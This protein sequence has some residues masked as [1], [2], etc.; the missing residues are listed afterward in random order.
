MLLSENECRGM[1]RM[2]TEAATEDAKAKS[3]G[4]DS[5]CYESK[6]EEIRNAAT[7]ERS[8]VNQINLRRLYEA[9]VPD[10]REA[11]RMLE[12]DRYRR[13][14]VFMEA[15]SPVKTTH[16]SNVLSNIFLGDM[17]AEMESP[18]LIGGDLLTK[19]PAESQGPEM[20]HGIAMIGD[21]AQ[22][23]GEGEEYPMVGLSEKF[24]TQPRK[25]KDG[26]I[27][28]ITDEVIW[29]NKLASVVERAR[30]A[31]QGMALTQEKDRLSTVL[32]ITNSY[33]RNGGPV[34][35]TYAD[36]HTQGDFDNLVASNAMTDYTSINA[37]LQRLFA[38]VDLDTGEPVMVGTNFQVVYPHQLAV[39]AAFAF[40][41]TE[42]RQVNGS[43]TSIGGNPISFMKEFGGMSFEFKSNQY[44]SSVQGNATSWYVGNFRD[45]FEEREVFP[46]QMFVE[47][48]NSSAGFSRDIAMR[49][50]V[51]RKSAVG[52]RN[53]QKVVK[54]TQ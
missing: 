17:L 27:I 50:K 49:M 8:I 32:G 5:Y 10:G 18:S 51:R 12:P 41:A 20:I 30:Q 24:V 45:A 40:G 25:V 2:L 7:N 54:C 23:I 22:D 37:A 16:F 34:Q 47:D 14:G 42:V 44:V 36:T 9:L 53:P 13:S 15:G 52:V 43:N 4:Q 48:R 1:A 6:L 38:Q 21:V 31:T 39:N 33:S 3:G 35:A 46:V 28:A 29:E 19:R 11:L 26:F